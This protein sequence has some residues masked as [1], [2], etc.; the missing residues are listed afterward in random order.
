MI[1]YKLDRVLRELERFGAENDAQAT[2][3][4][5]K[6]LNITRETGE[7]LL[8]LIRATKVA[9]VLEIGT[10]NGYSTLWLALAVQPLNG[11]VT[12]LDKSAYKDGLARANFARSEMQ[13]WI[14]NELADA[15]EFL[16]RQPREAFEFVFLDS[17]RGEYVGWWPDIQR[18]LV[19][20]GLL[21]IDNAISHARELEE[22]SDLIARTP[23]YITSLVPVGKGE[24]VVLKESA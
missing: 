20:G 2:G 1:P 5:Y 15:G 23:G 18:V 11:K 19:P 6:M 9:R 8:L 7:F 22:F 14:R 16:K 17:E 12:T 4:S 21:V 13:P 24:L 3:R 10:S